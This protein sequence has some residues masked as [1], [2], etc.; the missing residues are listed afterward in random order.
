[1][2]YA[3]IVL[4]SRRKWWI[5]PCPA[6]DFTF[7]F[8]SFCNWCFWRRISEDTVETL[9]QTSPFLWIGKTYKYGAKGPVY[10]LNFA[11]K[12][13]KV[14]GYF[15]CLVL[16]CGF[17]ISCT[18]I[19][20]GCLMS[21]SLSWLSTVHGDNTWVLVLVVS[22]NCI[23]SLLNIIVYLCIGGWC[24][25]GEGYICWHVFSRFPCLSHG[26]LMQLG[27]QRF[28]IHI[29]L[30][31]KFYCVTEICYLLVSFHFRWQL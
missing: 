21:C 9:H 30:L 29:L 25:N 8:F 14:T 23:F 28:V 26:S 24:K 27:K 20:V 11:R 5:E 10:T 17:L 22:F 6:G 12:T 4:W 18:L 2:F 15:T 7:S 31:L 16:S 1:M 13:L 3:A 19:L